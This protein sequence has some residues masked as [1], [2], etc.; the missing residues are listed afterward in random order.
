MGDDETV[1]ASFLK[2]LFFRKR[3]DRKVRIRIQCCVIRVTMMSIVLI[4]PPSSLKRQQE[5]N[6]MGDKGRYPKGGLGIE[7]DVVRN[8]GD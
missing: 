3:Y 1:E 8:H 2:S 6:G 4:K 7:T 5:A